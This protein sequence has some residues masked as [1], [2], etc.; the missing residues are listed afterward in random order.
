MTGKKRSPKYPMLGLP[1]ALKQINLVWSKNQMHAAPRE[2]VAKALGYNALHGKSL[3]LIAALIQYGLLEQAGKELRVSQLAMQYLHPESEEE[4]KAALR[5]AA[6]KPPLFSRL[7]EKFPGGTPSDEL[8]LNYLVRQ[9]FLPKAAEKALRAYRE[10]NELVDRE[11]G[12]YN[13]DLPSPSSD[14]DAMQQHAPPAVAGPPAKRSNIAP[15]DFRVAMDGEFLVE[16]N[17]SGLYQESVDRLVKWLTANRELVPKA[18]RQAPD[19]KERGVE[20]DEQ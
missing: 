1:E 15:G 6:A 3:R 13:E 11:C 16:I 5:N 7:N 2:V 19:V 17:G 9:S 4:K 14:D 8:V 10:T 12:Y 20:E 18:N